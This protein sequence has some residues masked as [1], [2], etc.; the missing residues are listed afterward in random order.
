M[1]ITA[2]IPARYKSSRFEGK[3]LADIKGKPMIWWVYQR[4]KTVQGLDNIY[5]ATDD[6]RIKDVCEKEKM[7]VIMT[8]EENPTPLNRIHEF[9]EKI[10]CDWYICINGDEPMIEP[11]VISKAVEACR[12]NPNGY[13]VFNC[14][15]TVKNPVELIDFTNLK[16]VVN[17]RGEGVYISRSPIPYP[18]NSLD[19]E[20]KKYV[21][22][23]CLTKHA[24]DFY[25]SRQRGVIERIEDNDLLRFIE[26]KFTVAFIDVNTDSLSVDTYKDLERV[27]KIIS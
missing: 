1:N 26:N 5:I 13:E 25:A 4:V 18:K 21:G 22:I 3:P 2:V 15:T 10:L 12:Q 20:Y 23:T 8:S 19:F 24:L 16:I 7:P 9:S 14:M 17:S 27:R 11:D 6:E